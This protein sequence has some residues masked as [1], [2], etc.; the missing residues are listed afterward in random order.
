MQYSQRREAVE[1]HVETSVNSNRVLKFMRYIP[2]TS[3]NKKLDAHHYEFYLQYHQ[4]SEEEK[5]NY[6]NG[7]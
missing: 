7:S 1:V 4:I 6:R 3:S 5:E 2:G